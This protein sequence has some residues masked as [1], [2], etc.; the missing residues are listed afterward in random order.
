MRMRFRNA[1]VSIVVLGLMAATTALAD[2]TESRTPP[3]RLWLYFGLD[4]G[5]AKVSSG[6]PAL[7]LDKSGYQISAKAL[8]SYYWD[9]WVMDF[10]PGYSF[11]RLR[12]NSAAAP[13]GT[14][15]PVRIYTDNAFLELSPRYRAGENW[16]LGLAA[17]LLMGSDVSFS[18]YASAKVSS[19]FLVGPRV[20]YETLGNDRRWRFGVQALT[21][22]N[23][24]NRNL[25]VIAA[26]IQYGFPICCQTR[27]AEKEEKWVQSSPEPVTQEYTPPPPEPAEP[28]SPPLPAETMSV[29]ASGGHV[30]IQLPEAVLRFATGKAKLT[31]RGELVLEKVAKELRKR[32]LAWTAITVTGHTD[33]RGSNA[34]NL[35]LSRA[36]AQTVASKLQKYG[37][38]KHKIKVRGRG[39]EELLDPHNTTSA[40]ARN[41]RVEIDVTSSK[42][43]SS[44]EL[45]DGLRANH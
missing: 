43:A 3:R 4:A 30:R 7:E 6:A 8:L 16:Q 22:L 5:Y 29:V 12:G 18:E 28:V 11:N 41:R 40:W 27:A 13:A 20:D 44:E 14:E 31:D 33:Q 45:V 39:E 2:S 35:K 21:D 19:A 38:P 17:N 34:A 26:D 37:I 10:G 15:I 25:W 36:R 23:I 32:P 24:Q 42:E 1:T 9:S